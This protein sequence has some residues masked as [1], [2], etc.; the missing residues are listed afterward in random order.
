MLV[1]TNERDT[2]TEIFGHKVPAPVGFAPVGINKIYH[3]QGELP[4]AK[5]AGGL[6]LPYCLSTAGSQSI[7]DVGAAN[8]E[9]AAAATSAPGE[10]GIRFFQLY[11]PH[12]DEL[13]RSLLQRAVDSGFSACILTLDTWQLGWRHDDV[14]TSN[15]A[16]YHGIGADLGLSDP[17]FQK[18]LKE[19]GIDPRKQ[20][21][22]A[23]ALWIDNV[24][25][26]RAHTWEKAVWAM[27]LW[28][29][30]SGGKPFC[31][32]GIQSVAD[33]KKSVELGFDGIVVSNHAGRQVDG[34]VA[35]L[36]ALEKI[37]DG[38]SNASTPIS[39]L[40]LP[41]HLLTQQPSGRRQNQH[42]VRFRHPLSI[43]HLQSAGPR[44]Q[45]CF[46]R[47]ALDLGSVYH[48]RNWCTARHKEFACR[49]GYPDECWR[50][51][52][53]QR[54]HEGESREWAQGLYIIAR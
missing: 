6:G 3:P 37:V 19:K 38:E 4:V 27:K 17:V 14:A 42:H 48:G 8:D 18:R 28:K 53:H 12:D 43:R 47:T 5:A 30:L 11:M 24:W 52:E 26:G 15:Y 34:A 40:F 45:I 23:G 2:A 7:E 44:R 41:E 39:S 36:D 25:H 22:E 35:S 29:E 16:F 49:S 31:L 33:A 10:K 50:L 51:Q 13:T 46:R 1:D 9:G 32:K 54:N 20:P 21:N